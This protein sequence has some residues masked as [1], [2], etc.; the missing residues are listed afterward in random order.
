MLLLTSNAAADSIRQVGIEILDMGSPL[1]PHATQQTIRLLRLL[2]LETWAGWTCAE[3]LEKTIAFAYEFDLHLV[4]QV[5]YV[6]KYDFVFAGVLRPHVSY[7]LTGI[8]RRVGW[9]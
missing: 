3:T 7:D 6:A 5:D 4:T 2:R 9:P 8:D 1:V